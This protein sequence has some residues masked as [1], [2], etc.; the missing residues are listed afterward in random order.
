MLLNEKKSLGRAIVI[1]GLVLAATSCQIPGPALWNGPGIVEPRTELTVSDL[2]SSVVE[3]LVDMTF[4]ER[5]EWANDATVPF[6]GSV[7]FAES[8]I[9]GMENFEAGGD[10]YDRTLPGF[11]VD[12][13]TDDQNLIPLVSGTV[14]TERMAVRYWDIVVGA[15]QVWR[16]DADDGWNRGSFPLHLINRYVGAA[17][18]CV[19]TFVYTEDSISNVH[20]QCS[21]ETAVLSAQRV[22]DLRTVVP[23]AYSP[24]TFSNAAEFV[25]DF[26]ERELARIPTAALT[27]IDRDGRIAEHF[28]R[29][30]WTSA[31]TSH[32]AVY[33]DG[34]LY[35]N[36]PRTRHGIY[37]YLD[38]MRHGVFSVTKSMA[39]ALSMFYFAERYDESIFDELIADYVP[40]FAGRADWQGVTFSDALNMVTGTSANE[41]ELLYEPLTIAEDSE[42]AINNIAGFQ[43]SPVPPGEV[44]NYATTNTFVL[45]YALE[46]YVQS[47]EGPD[48][49]YWDLVHENVLVPI[50]AKDFGLIFTRDADPSD[51]VPVLGMGAYPTLDN[52]AKIARLIFDEGKHGGVQLLNRNKIREALGRTEWDGYDAWRG[53][54]LS[55]SHSF[56]SDYVL[57]GLRRVKVH[58]MEGLGDNRII[59]FPSGLISFQFTDEFDEEFNQLVRA[60]ERVRRSD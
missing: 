55:Y 44:F 33:M 20:I 14:E 50:G 45:S 15:G 19:A 56:W 30:I 18:N 12:F 16:E 43:T 6:S 21:Q 46:N 26:D 9:S 7:S 60:V 3:P 27:E 23:A 25:A 47:I 49:H 53:S 13:V 2:N 22:G 24:K 38:E 11:S 29:N 31:S 28:D 8:Q 52:A 57:V 41:G 35:I 51:A 54:G 40:A 42:T 17:R 1:L 39:G 10:F 4:F 36:P 34:T 59:F 5:P 48:V 32:G 58:F 37:P